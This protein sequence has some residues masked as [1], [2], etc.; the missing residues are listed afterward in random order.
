MVNENLHISTA[1]LSLLARFEGTVLHI[2]KDQAGLKT[3]GVGH[4]LTPAENASGAFSGGITREE[5]L[6]LLAKDAAKAENII[7][8]YIEVELNQ[9]QFDALVS[10]VFNCGG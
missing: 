6:Q 3:V 1:G 10:M 2:Y 8:A 9:N 5:A 4:L 7:K